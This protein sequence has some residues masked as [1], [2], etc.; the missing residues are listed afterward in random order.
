MNGV[1]DADKIDLLYV[2]TLKSNIEVGSDFRRDAMSGLSFSFSQDSGVSMDDNNI[3]L[4][5]KISINAVEESEDGF[6]KGEFYFQFLFNIEN[7]I[8]LTSVE[9]NGVVN[10]SG[11][12]ATT[13]MGIAYSTSRGLVLS[14]T[15]QSVLEGVLLP[16]VNPSNLIKSE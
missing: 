11:D 13:I 4:N 8:D 5:L 10:V 15:E 7:L 6:A 3:I 2:K 16:V 1:V 14:A 9:E 12:L